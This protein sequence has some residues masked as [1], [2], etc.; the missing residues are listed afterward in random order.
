MIC[1]LLNK[2]R[3]IEVP[4]SY[5]KRV[6][7]ESKHSGSFIALSKTALKMLSL[8]IKRRLML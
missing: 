1:F 6:G 7:G 3:V 4:V 5:I 8:I 2:S